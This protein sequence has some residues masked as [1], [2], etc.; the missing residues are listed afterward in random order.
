VKVTPNGQVKVLDFGLAK[1][2]PSRGQN[3]TLYF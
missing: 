1:A 2:W 3:Q